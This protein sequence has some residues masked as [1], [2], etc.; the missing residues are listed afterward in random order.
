MEEMETHRM[1]ELHCRFP[2]LESHGIKVREVM[3][4]VQNKF[5]SATNGK[6]GTHSQEKFWNLEKNCQSSWKSRGVSKARKSMNPDIPVEVRFWPVY[7]HVIW[8]VFSFLSFFLFS[9]FECSAFLQQSRRSIVCVPCTDIC[10]HGRW[11]GGPH[12]TSGATH[13]NKT[14]TKTVLLWGN[15]E[16]GAWGKSVNLLRP[17]LYL[18]LFV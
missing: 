12:L 7:F 17:N 4:I 1:L 3:L 15:A 14:R 2:G 16:H 18:Y 8:T 11:N 10:S 9:V 5:V 13:T 6:K